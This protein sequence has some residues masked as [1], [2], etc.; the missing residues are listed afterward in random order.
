MMCEGC[1]HEP[2]T[3]TWT[4]PG[5]R[6]QETHRLCAGCYEICQTET[7]MRKHPEETLKTDILKALAASGDEPMTQRELRTALAIEAAEDSALVRALNLL[8]SDRH[9]LILAVAGR[10]RLTA[11]GVVTVTA[12]EAPVKDTPTTSTAP[13]ASRK[14]PP[15]V[16]AR[17][18]HHLQRVIETNLENARRGPV[19]VPPVA[20]D[21]PSVEEPPPI[22]PPPAGT[23]T[24]SGAAEEPR[25]GDLRWVSHPTLATLGG[26]E[27][28]TASLPPRV[29][30]DNDAVTSVATGRVAVLRALLYEVDRSLRVESPDDVLQSAHAALARLRD[31]VTELEHEVGVLSLAVTG[32]GA[33]RWVRVGVPGESRGDRHA[34]MVTQTVQAGWVALQ[35]DEIV[36]SAGTRSG[37]IN[38]TDPFQN[39]AGRIAIGQAMVRSMLGWSS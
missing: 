33:P 35:G 29:R 3:E 9:G 13:R 10:Y 17:T 5:R 24:M 12:P 22:A 21:A 15:G 23:H 20:I 1:G 6:S 19:S 14:T 11:K 28:V 30:G 34:L 27:P 31:R 26:E 8:A 39:D 7:A 4:V 18:H 16:S 36:W 32:V 37:T 25:Q 2:A 38:D